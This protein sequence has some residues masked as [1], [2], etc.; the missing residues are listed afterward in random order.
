MLVTGKEVLLVAFFLSIGLT[1]TPTWEAL[2]VAALLALLIPV[3]S[4]AFFGLLWMMRLRYRTSALA[5][6]ALGNYSEF[7]L[8]VAAVVAAS[9]VVSPD[10][11]VVLALA[12]AMSF[13]LSA[14]L[15]RLTPRIEEWVNRALPAQ[16][17]DRITPDDR[18]IDLGDAETL[19]LGMGRV[20][21][22]TVERL[23]EAHGRR[24]VG[25]EHDSGRV[26][27]LRAQGF[28][29]VEADATDLDFWQ[30]VRQGRT[31]RARDARSTARTCSCSSCCAETVSPARSRRSPNVVRNWTN[32]G[33][34]APMRRS[35]STAAPDRVS[36]TMRSS[37]GSRQGQGSGRGR[38]TERPVPEGRGARS[39]VR[40]GPVWCSPQR[41]T[42]DRKSRTSGPARSR[43]SSK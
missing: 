4:A 15:N 35:T 34:A 17:P 24:A 5:G 14:V 1:G 36:P 23:H 43:R 26:E 33:R 20:G 13:L 28:R 29:V 38:R 19:V 22:A 32:C 25:V 2:G 6:L 37:R 18:P 42:D 27:Q 8:I 30:R 40:C 12:V 9:G 10:W 3:K 31:G 41:S 39:V 11:V 7:A 21:Q 16:D